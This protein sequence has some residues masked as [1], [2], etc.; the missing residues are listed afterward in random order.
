MTTPK[1]ELYKLNQTSPFIELYTIDCTAVG[2]IVYWF[3]PNVNEDGSPISF[4]GRAYQSLPIQTSGWELTATGEQPRPTLSLSN[5]NSALLAAVVT[6]GDIVN[7]KVTRLR[8]FEKFLDGKPEA[9]PTAYLDP[10][11]VYYVY[12]K[13]AHNKH[14]ISWQLASPVE[15]FASML[16]ARQYL[17]DRGFPGISRYR[18][19]A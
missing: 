8:T 5:V 7:A 4:A 2:G 10:V 1:Q 9:D 18:G 14:V 17:K 16:P 13:T 3:T 6:M 19:T 11:D 15:A 12:Q